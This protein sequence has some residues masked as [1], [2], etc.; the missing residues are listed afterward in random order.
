MLSQRR[1]IMNYKKYQKSTIEIFTQYIDSKVEKY[2]KIYHFNMDYNGQHR[3]YNNEADA[4]KHTFMQADLTLKFDENISKL[5]GDDH[6]NKPNNDPNEMNMDLWNNRQGREIGI[7][8]KTNNKTIKI[9]LSNKAANLYPNN[10][11]VNNCK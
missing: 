10:F 2:Y 8:I 3:S 11:Y 9:S 5:I 7:K 1:K 6:E 4:F